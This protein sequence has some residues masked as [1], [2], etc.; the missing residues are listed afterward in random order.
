MASKTWPF[1]LPEVG[2]YFPVWHALPTT[3]FCC[4]W[5]CEGPLHSKKD[6][7]IFL[8]YWYWLSPQTKQ[9]SENRWWGYWNSWQWALLQWAVSVLCIAN[10]VCSTENT[11]STNHHEDSDAFEKDIRENWFS[12]IK[13]FKKF[14]SS[15]MECQPDLM[16]ILSKEVMLEKPS[17]SV[18]N[19]HKCSDFI[20]ERLCNSVNQKMSIY[21]TIKRNR[22]DLFWSKRIITVPKVK[23]EKAALKEQIQVYSSLYVG[24]KSRQANLDEFFCHRNQEYPPLLCDYGSIRKPTSKADSV[25]GCFTLV[26]SFWLL[27]VILSAT[28]N[29]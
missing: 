19:V 17:T 22:L 8:N 7:M 28:S 27:F 4:R 1:R 11:L 24:F 25:G 16:N 3:S 13:T 5:I 6:W 15:S 10:M 9:V 20:K 26:E 12:V 23:R 29:Y 14:D 21:A 2:L 18:R